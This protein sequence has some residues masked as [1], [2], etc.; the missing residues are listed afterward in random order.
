MNYMNIHACLHLY[1]AFISSTYFNPCEIPV[2]T[3]SESVINA[4]VQRGVK[5]RMINLFKVIKDN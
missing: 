4:N 5:H 1:S 3:D 2:K